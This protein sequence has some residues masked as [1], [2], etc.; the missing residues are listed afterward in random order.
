MRGSRAG[1][2]QHEYHRD[3][4]N[5]S[6]L[7]A[8]VGHLPEPLQQVG[9]HPCRSGEIV[10]SDRIRRDR[11]ERREPGLGDVL[12]PQRV[13][14]R[15]FNQRHAPEMVSRDHREGVPV[16][17]GPPISAAPCGVSCPGHYPQTNP[18]RDVQVDTGHERSDYRKPIVL[19]NT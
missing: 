4:V 16:N 3:R 5:P 15:P 19:P 18:L 14:H 12:P 13:H 2:A 8:A 11:T 6:L 10:G 1:R 7:A 17:S 9:V